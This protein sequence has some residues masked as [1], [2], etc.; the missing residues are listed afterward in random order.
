[1]SEKGNF[2]GMDL[3]KNGGSAVTAILE[4]I[5]QDNE[6]TVIDDFGPFYKVKVPLRMVVKRETVEEL[7][8]QDWDMDQMHIHMASYFGFFEEWDQDQIIIKWDR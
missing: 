7:L 4:A 3:D 2:V 1:M 6:G 8:G 5:Q